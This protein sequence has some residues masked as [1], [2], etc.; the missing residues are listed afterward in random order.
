MSR[1]DLGTDGTATLARTWLNPA[2]LLRRPLRGMRDWRRRRRA[3]IIAA[4]AVTTLPGYSA[5][6]YWKSRRRTIYIALA[7]FAFLYGFAFALLAPALLLPLLVPLIALFGLL[8][9]VLPDGLR[10]PTQ[11]LVR[12]FFCYAVAIQLWPYYLA[13]QLPGMPLLEI[14][15]LFMATA[16]FA[17]LVSY[18]V[19]PEFRRQTQAIVNAWPLFFKL[20]LAFL[21]VQILSLV[22]ATDHASAVQKFIRNQFSWTATLIITCYVLSRPGMTT[23]WASV[24]RT[25]AVILAFIAFFEFRNQQILWAKHIPSFLTVS[26]PA[27]VRLLEPVFREGEYRVT[28]T[29]SVSLAFAE[30]MALTL[31]LFLHYIFTG[32]NMKM[33]W[34]TGICH[35]LVVAA[36]VLTRARVG[37]V[38]IVIAHTAYILPWALRRWR[39]D[40]SSLVAPAVVLA[41]PAM[42]AILVAVVLFVGRVRSFVLGDGSTTS[43]T[44]S[45]LEQAIQ[46]VPVLLHRPLFGYGPSQG[47]LALNFRN[48]AGELSIDS[49]ILSVV[50]DYGVVGFTLYYA[51]LFAAL[52][53]AARLSLV[54]R[55]FESSY[56][57]AAAVSLLVWLATRIALAQEDNMSTMYMILGLVAAANYR[58]TLGERGDRELGKV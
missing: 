58:N 48:P 54:A 26:D 39:E 4:R 17:M 21:F 42:V 52:Y 49:S 29:F 55:S 31:P 35:V 10:P 19:S 53:K 15:R 37:A 44:V 28:T 41:Y 36:I 51:M 20:F 40:K 56:V 8:I 34:L 38:G 23:L 9:W 18:S 14:R 30:F 12:T 27:M 47:A 45:R 25:A 46:T 3:R 2:T 43:S 33:R 50:L 1:L 32:K 22:L 16:L 6:N 5:N 11:I 57:T 7:I 24:I 13:V